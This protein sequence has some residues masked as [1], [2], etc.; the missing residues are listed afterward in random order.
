MSEVMWRCHLLL[1][2]I[3]AAVLISWRTGWKGKIAI[4]WTHKGA[5]QRPYGEVFCWQDTCQNWKVKSKNTFFF[6][7]IC[8]CPS[9]IPCVQTT[10]Q[11][12]VAQVW[13]LQHVNFKLLFKTLT[14]EGTLLLITVIVY[15]SE[16]EWLLVIGSRSPDSLPTSGRA[17]EWV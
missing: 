13:R 2:R 10:K 4:K 7:L 14:A 12:R 9:E 1:E 5:W 16:T 17:Q 15:Q 11:F 3:I 6:F 8:G